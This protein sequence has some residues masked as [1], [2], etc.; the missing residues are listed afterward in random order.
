MWFVLK[1]AIRLVNRTRLANVGYA[2]GECEFTSVAYDYTDMAEG[3]ISFVAALIMLV[4]DRVKLAQLKHLDQTSVGRIVPGHSVPRV[5][6]Q[7]QWKNSPSSRTPTENSPVP[8]SL[9]SAGF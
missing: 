4:T 1:S 8:K 5:V 6:G 3:L 7:P 2:S 9:P